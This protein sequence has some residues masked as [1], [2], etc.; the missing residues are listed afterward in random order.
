MTTINR[1]T[2]VDDDGSGMTGTILNN[3][4]LQADIYDKVDG[5]LATLDG[6]DVSQD[7]AIAAN[8]PH[9]ILSA[10]HVDTTP[11]AL[12]IGDILVV[13]AGNKLVR[14][15][16]AANGQVLTLASGVPA[17]ADPV[18]EAGAWIDNPYSA[19]N[20][21]ATA[22][23]TWTVEAADQLTY[24]YVLVG[25]ICT[26]NLRIGSSSIGGTL[27]PELWVTLPVNCPVSATGS[28]AIFLQGTGWEMGQAWITG[29]RLTIMRSTR[30]SFSAQTNTAVVYTTIT[31]E[32]A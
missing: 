17:W 28:C 19:A 32:I 30:A 25:K 10:Q 21:S 6:K 3:A 9:S 22:G 16:K 8:G 2:W 31:F 20:F 5:A 4:R 7:T 18:V 26:L 23:M 14:L 29:T 27:G 1:A 11:A 24:R 13:G 15:P 12:T